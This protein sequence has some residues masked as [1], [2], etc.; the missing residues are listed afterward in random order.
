M[1]IPVLHYLSSP[2]LER[3]ALPADPASCAVYLTAGIGPA[4]GGGGADNFSFNVVTPDQLLAP[5]EGA[6][7]GRG[8][9]VVA[10][11]SWEG[12]ERMLSKLL[13][14]ADRDRWTESARELAK[15]LH[16]GCE[17]YTDVSGS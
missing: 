10:H 9:L 3:S 7:W 14:H 4:R 6:R 12:V 8:Y 13:L 11:F 16:W 5:G 15:E 1:A 2:E 17:H